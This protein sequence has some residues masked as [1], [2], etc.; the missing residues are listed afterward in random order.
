MLSAV[1]PPVLRDV[2]CSIATVKMTDVLPDCCRGPWLG[3]PPPAGLPRHLRLYLDL[4]CGCCTAPRSHWW[5]SRTRVWSLS[6]NLCF[7][8]GTS[9]V[10]GR[11]SQL[12][13]AMSSLATNGTNRGLNEISFSTNLTKTLRFVP[14][15]ANLTQFGTKTDI[16][17]WREC[18]LGLICGPDWHQMGKICESL[19]AKTWS[20]N[21]NK[22]PS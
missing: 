20:T 19:N 8:P 14:F 9:P 5:P 4:T 2:K 17:D 13:P 22:I 11:N 16:P 3:S 15:R 6:G 12:S 1:L 10:K 18:L 7:H 21:L